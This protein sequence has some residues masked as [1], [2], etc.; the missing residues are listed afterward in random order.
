[1]NTRMG[2]NTNRL[3]I[4]I[5]SSPDGRHAVAAYT[6]QAGN[7]WTYSSYNIPCPSNV[8]FACNKLTTRFDHAAEAGRSYSYRTFV[9]VGDLTTVKNSAMKL[10]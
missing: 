10:K 6:P 1:M 9:I 8:E 3:L 4:P 7:F 2:I 5:L